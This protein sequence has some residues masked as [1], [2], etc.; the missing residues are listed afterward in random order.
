[1]NDLLRLV[2]DTLLNEHNIANLLSELT[3]EGILITGML[4]YVYK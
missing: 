3:L 4:H 2:R 1:M